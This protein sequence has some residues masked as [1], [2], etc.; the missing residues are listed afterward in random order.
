MMMTLMKMP[1]VRDLNGKKPSGKKTTVKKSVSFKP[2]VASKRGPP[3]G[4][5]KGPTSDTLVITKEEYKRLAGVEKAF[6]KVKDLNREMFEI[7]LY[8]TMKRK[9]DKVADNLKKK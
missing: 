4:I 6:L 9:P 7:M 2:A 1:Q 3:K 8:E 5:S